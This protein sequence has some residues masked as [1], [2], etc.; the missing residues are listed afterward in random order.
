MKFKGFYQ[1]FLLE[2]QS[3]DLNG[4]LNLNLCKMGENLYLILANSL[5]GIRPNYRPNIRP[6]VAEYSVS[7]DT[8]FSCIG[9]TLRCSIG[10]LL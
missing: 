6:V 2:L 1:T 5:A 4:T 9:R 7:A 10:A 8:N 3:N